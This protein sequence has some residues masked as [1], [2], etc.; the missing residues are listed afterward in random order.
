MS[1]P[2]AVAL[3]VADQAT[4]VR[5]LGVGYQGHTPDTFLDV[6]TAASVH[7]LIDVRLTAA[8]RKPGFAKTRLHAA[9]RA[10]DIGYLHLPQLGNPASNRPGFAQPGPARIAAQCHYRTRLAEPGPA[11]AVDELLQA[12]GSNPTALLCVEADP[13][14][15]HRSV[16]LEYL[17][18]HAATSPAR[19]IGER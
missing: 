12:A 10:A 5:L 16:L 18:T 13:A 6:L 19:P 11:A 3:L 9:L 2:L 7:L 8:S 15:C 14:A 1:R 17:T 4:A